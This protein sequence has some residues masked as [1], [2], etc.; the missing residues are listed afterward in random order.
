MTASQSNEK[1]ISMEELFGDSDNDDNCNS[2][3]IKSSLSRSN[4]V[5]DQEFDFPNNKI[6]RLNRNVSSTSD[7]HS[8]NI[9]KQI[10][11]VNS[12]TTFKTPKDFGFPEEE[13]AQKK[14]L[15]LTYRNHKFESADVPIF[16]IWVY[17]CV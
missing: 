17:R 13:A 2:V 5:N 9:S 7:N 3:A 11:L 6:I 4:D 12:S 10:T 16:K 1:K 15:S 14:S 8:K